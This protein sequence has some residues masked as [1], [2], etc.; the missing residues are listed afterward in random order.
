M[1]GVYDFSFVLVL[2]KYKTRNF[3]ETIVYVIRNAVADGANDYQ[4]YSNAGTR[5]AGNV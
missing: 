4:V 5:I 3:L 2:L 1:I